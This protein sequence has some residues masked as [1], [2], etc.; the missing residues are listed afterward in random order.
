MANDSYD[1]ERNHMEGI[2]YVKGCAW[3]QTVDERGMLRVCYIG[4]VSLIGLR[5]FCREKGWSLW[6]EEGR[7]A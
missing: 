2:T 3:L 1:K 6:T 4:R 5:A 7:K